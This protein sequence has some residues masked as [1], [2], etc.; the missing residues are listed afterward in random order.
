MIEPY[1]NRTQNALYDSNNDCWS[2][3]TKST[4]ELIEDSLQHE[5]MHEI[6]DEIKLYEGKITRSALSKLAGTATDDDLKYF[7]L[8]IAEI[9]RL[10]EEYEL[11]KASIK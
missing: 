11:L 10:R 2:L 1:R 9:K 7:D 6:I 8:Y 5:R 4:D 3:I